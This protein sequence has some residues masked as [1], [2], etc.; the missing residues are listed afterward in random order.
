MKGINVT[1][2]PPNGAVNLI[3]ISVADRM[4][5][6]KVDMDKLKAQTSKQAV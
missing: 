2:L 4:D 1:R 3:N 6:Q 5:I